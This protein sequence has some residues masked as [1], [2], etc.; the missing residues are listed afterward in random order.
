ML[1]AG[2]VTVEAGIGT[3]RKL[4]KPTIG[5]YLACVIDTLTNEMHPVGPLR[6]ADIF[7][8]G[9]VGIGFGTAPV[10]VK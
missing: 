4:N 9:V 3:A 10:I 5:L 1:S 8:A 7:S 2:M 6:H